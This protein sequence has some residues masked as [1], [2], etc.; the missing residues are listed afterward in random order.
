MQPT[1]VSF[2]LFI[3]LS[4]L[5]GC[6][7]S[8]AESS[9][10]PELC[11]VNSLVTPYFIP[12]LDT[13]RKTRGCSIPYKSVTTRT[14]SKSQSHHLD[15]KEMHVMAHNAHLMQEVHVI[16]LY[17]VT[18]SFFDH[19]LRS[20]TPS[21]KLS[22]NFG[23]GG[24]NNESDAKVLGRLILVLN[25]DHPVAWE[26]VANHNSRE[27]TNDDLYSLPQP[28]IV[29]SE[30]ST[31]E[32]NFN[33]NFSHKIW[34]NKKALQRFVKREYSALA[35]YT[36]VKGANHM[37]LKVGSVSSLIQNPGLGTECNVDSLTESR[38]LTAYSTVQLKTEGCFHEDYIGDN[39]V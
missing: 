3:M 4:I 27:D 9:D 1:V 16:M 20:Q 32:G 21:V 30:G 10:N 29:V 8:I 36:E 15:K 34:P 23:Q 14:H 18:G 2:C 39:Q 31:V 6:R 11:I 13:P 7:S 35:S 37:E 12:L 25:S 28:L 19:H 17:S 5:L 38:V 26:V 24:A 33:F 22:V